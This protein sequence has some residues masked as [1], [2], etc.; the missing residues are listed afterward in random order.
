MKKCLVFSSQA[1]L[2]FLVFT[3]GVL[4]GWRK[5]NSSENR[6]FSRRQYS[7]EG[8]SKPLVK[9]SRLSSIVWSVLT[10]NHHSFLFFNVFFKGCC[11][12]VSFCCCER[13]KRTLHLGCKLIFITGIFFMVRVLGYISKVLI[14]VLLF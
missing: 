11:R 12:P 9:P 5:T 3:T 10:Q 13:G 7:F 4:L 8:I 14:G 6:C 1:R 2:N